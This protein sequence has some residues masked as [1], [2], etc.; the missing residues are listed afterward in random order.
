[1][2]PALTAFLALLMLYFVG[3]DQ[4]ATSEFGAT[5]TSMSTST[6]PDTCS[7]SLPLMALEGRIIRREL[8]AGALAGLRH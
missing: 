4:G 3:I 8:V 2:W 7:D 5:P 1:V 6:T